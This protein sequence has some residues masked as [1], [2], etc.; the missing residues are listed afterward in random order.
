[1]TEET[2]KRMDKIE[3][4]LAESRVSQKIEW[5]KFVGPV[6]T[7]VVLFVGIIGSWV[8]NNAAIEALQKTTATQSRKID[9]VESTARK[10]EVNAVRESSVLKSVKED[11]SE[12]KSDVK[13][14]LET[15]H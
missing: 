10:L 1:M 15:N 5:I 13:K 3:A 8:T 9:A 6:I 11:V 12:I 2:N 7:V 4:I 14:L